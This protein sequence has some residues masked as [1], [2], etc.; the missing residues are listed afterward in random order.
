MYPNL[1]ECFF[2]EWVLSYGQKQHHELN[3]KEFCGT[4][5]SAAA[6]TKML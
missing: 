6:V 1:Y 4:D 3:I 5:Y 2:A